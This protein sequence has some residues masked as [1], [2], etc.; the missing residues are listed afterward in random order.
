MLEGKSRAEIAA[1]LSD[2]TSDIA[3]A[4]VGNANVLTAA[5]CEATGN[6]PSDVCTSAGVK[7]GAVALAKGQQK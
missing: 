3:K 5:I 2:P 7:A 4:V 1:A 6:K